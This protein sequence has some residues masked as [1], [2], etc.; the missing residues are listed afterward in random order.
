MIA[1]TYDKGQKQPS[2]YSY[3]ELSKTQF[4]PASVVLLFLATVL[5]LVGMLHT[6]F[7]LNAFL[8]VFLIFLGFKLFS[9][10]SANPY[11]MLFYTWYQESLYLWWIK[12]LPKSYK[13][14]KYY[15]IDCGC[16]YF[17][18]FRWNLIILKPILL[19]NHEIQYPR[20]KVRKY[21]CLATKS[22]NK[23][24]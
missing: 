23:L 14:L 11:T 12:P 9:N 6:R 10:S 21:Y 8:K 5:F 20:K 3:N 15:V 13:V 18:P 2:S 17:C 22:Y 19:V 4:F 16:F 24:D 7:Y 1:Y